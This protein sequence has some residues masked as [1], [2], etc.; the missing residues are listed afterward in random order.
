MY[1]PLLRQ[2][3]GAARSLGAQARYRSKNPR[4]VLTIPQKR[5]FQLS[6]ERMGSAGVA[7]APMRQDPPDVVYDRYND[8]PR[9]TSIPVEPG[10]AV[11]VSD[12]THGV[13]GSMSKASL[14]RVA[15]LGREDSAQTTSTSANPAYYHGSKF[16]RV[17]YW[18]KIG[19]WKDVGEKEFLSYRWNTAKDVQG[20]AKLYEFLQE[21]LPEK[22]PDTPE[23]ER[24]RT[25]EDFI[26]DVMQGIALAPMSIRL[27]PHILASIDWNDPLG[28]PLS[29]QFIPKK[30]TFQPDHPK[31]E[32]DSLHES[33]DSPVEGLVHRYTDKCLFLA[34]SHC[35]LY[36]KYCTRSY[37]VGADTET[38]TKASLKPQRRRWEKM[39][40]YIA[41][42]PIIQDVV[43][44]GG[45]SYSLMP[46]HLAMIGSR[47]LEIPHVRRFRVA[48]K[49]LCV[50]PSRTLDP[51]DDW[52]D[53]LIK[54]SKEGRLRGKHVAMHTHFNH[55][56][57]FSWV[58]REA[59]QKLFANGVTVRN[60]SVLLKGVND[61]VNT[62][63][64][65][66]RELADNNIQPYYVYAGDLVKGVEDLRTP[67]S[68]ILDLEKEIRGSIAGFMTPQF[69][70]DLPGGGGKRLAASYQ[71][72]DRK[73]G[74]STFI[75]PAVQGE[76][77]EGKVYEYYDPLASLPS[78]GEGINFATLEQVAA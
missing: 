73:T 27:T 10:R 38:V 70:V 17:P 47:L 3:I 35:P 51:G 32:L 30:S 2:Q 16:D 1:P 57:E 53:E 13:Q 56:N 7:H 15:T 14:P 59:A 52:T 11:Q 61:D 23:Y 29:R 36:C 28:D 26:M 74:L 66:I 50:S 46:Q 33:D 19:R 49:G 22:M 44:S 20:K 4:R 62:M 77:K 39:L 75:A 71:T 64:T 72:Y 24:I 60:Q 9:G 5:Y 40:E 78:G 63:K 34:S 58:S 45:D 21:Q 31:L 67:L 48:T 65:L 8:S 42:T 55:P 6:A 76:G 41:A 12:Y 37:A 43:I 68:T 25:R 69:V 54:L 18:Q